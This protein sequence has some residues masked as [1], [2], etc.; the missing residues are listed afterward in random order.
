M[1][2]RSGQAISGDITSWNDLAKFSAVSMKGS[3]TKLWYLRL[4]SFR[5]LSLT[6]IASQLLPSTPRH[7]QRYCALVTFLIY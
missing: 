7:G 1:V 4:G 6:N 5:Q 3:E 2:V